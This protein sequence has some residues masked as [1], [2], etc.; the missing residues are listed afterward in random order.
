MKKSKSTQGAFLSFFKCQGLAR[1][2]LVQIKG[3]CCGSDSGGET[4]PPAQAAPDIDKAPDGRSTLPP[5]L[6]QQTTLLNNGG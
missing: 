3:G 2:Q 4:P 1:Q 6:Q 5:A